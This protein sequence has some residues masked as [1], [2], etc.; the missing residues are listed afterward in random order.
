MAEAFGPKGCSSDCEALVF[1]HEYEK[2]DNQ[3]ARHLQR[4]LAAARVR[5]NELEL[6]VTLRRDP[7]EERDDGERVRKDRWETG[8]RNIAHALGWGSK[9]FEV[10]DVVEAVRKLVG[11]KKPAPPKRSEDR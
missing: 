11:D 6:E 10:G 1:L 4:E 7:E 8:I 9:G 5:L 3:Y 2:V